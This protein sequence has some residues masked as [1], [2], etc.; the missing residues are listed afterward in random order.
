MV[1]DHGG[2][3]DAHEAGV[4]EGLDVLGTT[5]AHAGAEAADELIDGLAEGALVRHAGHDALRHE[6]A[7]VAGLRLEIAVLGA[8]LHGLDGAHAS[9]CLELTAIVD[10]CLAR[11]LLNAR[12]HG[13][14]H[15]G[16]AAGCEGLHDVAGIAEAAVGDHGDAEAVGDTGGVEDGGKLGH[17][18]AGHDA[19]GAD[20][21]RADADLDAVGA[22]VDEELSGLGGGDVADEDVDLRESLLY[23][24]ERT[25]HIGRMAV[26]RVDHHCVD[27]C[28]NESL[29]A[30]E[31]V[32]G[33]TDTGG[34]AETP[35]GVLAC[36]G[37]VLDL[38]DVA[39]GDEAYE[40]VVGVDHRELLDLMAEKDLGCLG[41][42]RAGGGDE[43]LLG[44]DPV[45]E[46]RHVGLEAEV[47]VGDDAHEE[48]LLVDH[49]NAADVVLLHEA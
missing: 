45:D 3:G 31:G 6:L 41:E 13:A 16:V 47:A 11:R 23:G 18:D 25:G 39:V 42:V 2:G 4:V 33:D 22:G 5:V 1:L 29:D 32:G 19:G 10:D 9:V 28:V 7:G 12:E 24:A 34:H 37:I 26:C 49:G 44:H 17:S 40:T 43:V 27:A 38:G 35:L 48:A 20:G 21:A 15:H 36:V 30:G 8:G 46:D 14:H